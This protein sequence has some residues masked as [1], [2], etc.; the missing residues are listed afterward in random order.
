[1]GNIDKEI[2]SHLKGNNPAF[3][4]IDAE[5]LVSWA[6]IVGGELTSNRKEDSLKN[7]QL[8]RFYDTVKQIER[9]TLRDA[10]D[11]T[12]DT[13]LVAQLLFLRPHLANAERKDRKIKP[14]RKALEPFLSSDV[15][16]QKKDLTRFVKYFEAIVAYTG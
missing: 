11:K 16:K 14:L 4:S 13:D 6:K 9:R 10:P 12:L 2:K 1:M 8:R 5:T 15:I 7:H 3:G